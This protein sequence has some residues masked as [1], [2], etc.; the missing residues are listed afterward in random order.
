EYGSKEVISNLKVS[1]LHPAKWREVI[2]AY[3]D[4]SEKEWKT[5]YGL[6]KTRMDKLAQIEQELKID[7]NTP[8]KEQDPMNELNELANK[9]RKRAGDFSDAPRSAKKFKSSVQ[10]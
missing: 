4:K 2:Q 10:Q 7:F 6:V 9:E 5:I 3:P 1:D 8:L